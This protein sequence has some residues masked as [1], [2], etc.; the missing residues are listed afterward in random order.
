MG[1][2]NVD[3]GLAESL[4]TSVQQRVLGLLFGQPRRSF[5]GAEIIRL[6]ESGTG[7][8]HRELQRLGHSGL[9][10]VTSVGSQKF[11]QANHK[12]PVYRELQ[13]LV[14]K[15]V[16]IQGTLAEALA[17]VAEHIHTAFVFGSFAKGK[18]TANSDI[19]LMV[20]GSRLE[21]PELYLA[22]ER[23]E[24]V[25]SRPINPHLMSATEWKKKLADRNHF[26]VKVL[27]RPKLFVIGSQDDL[28]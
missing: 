10:T 12:S 21:Y 15:T 2:P 27:A 6:A 8:V 24:K 23:A 9:V 5:Q 19:D 14:R 20:I 3:T 16:G 4:F 25:L 7:A 1:M 28:G 22:L 11:Y 26:V 13:G 17:P 18:E